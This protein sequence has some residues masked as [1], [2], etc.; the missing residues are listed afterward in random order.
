MVIIIPVSEEKGLESTVVTLDKVKKWALVDL[1]S[2]S[3]EPTFHDD[4]KDTGADFIEH[5]ILDNHDEDAID[6]INEGLFCLVSRE[7]KQIDELIAAFRF[8]ELD[9]LAF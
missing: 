3:I 9:E 8:R 7:E 5:I 4:W 2:D 1:T 6:F